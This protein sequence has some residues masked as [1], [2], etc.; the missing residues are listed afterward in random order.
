MVIRTN[1]LKV[2]RRDLAKA[3]IGRGVS[4][5][6][7]AEWSKVG[8]K[9]NDSKV[10]IGATPEYLAGHYILQSPSSFLPV[11]ALC[12]QPDEV[13]IDMAAA[14]GGKT[15][16]MA[17]LMKNKGTIIANDSQKAR[18][19]ALYANC[20]RLGVSNVIISNYDGRKLPSIVKNVDRVLLD[21]PCSGLGLISRDPSMKTQK[22]FKEISKLSAL[23]K[24]LLLAGIDC[25]NPHSKTGGYI[26][27]STCSV[28]VE[29][30]EAVINYALNHRYVK[31]VE[32][33]VQV[34]VS[35]VIAYKKYRFPA[36]MKLAR[37]VYPHVHNMDGFF[38]C[39]LKKFANGVKKKVV[40]EDKKPV[41][42]VS[43][44]DRKDSNGKKK[45]RKKK[46]RS[47]KEIE[48]E[49]LKDDYGAEDMSDGSNNVDVR[50][51]QESND[52]EPIEEDEV[53]QEKEESDMDEEK[54][55][56]EP[57]KTK[58][59]I[60]DKKQGARPEKKRKK[61]KE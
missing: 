2:K 20:Q 41:A 43:K 32:T 11:I 28:T 50:E 47:H 14:P 31:I 24:E 1:T 19:K 42:D 51:E 29:E 21:S 3:L 10:P 15:T 48:D 8:L 22:N 40:E 6:P 34:G 30:N 57:K 36:S 44:E 23:Q 9:V 16:Y 49:E 46:K 18:T 4:L 33:G 61:H 59:K 55:A 5:E 25:V 54:L 58:K 37:R 45:E 27:Y 26:V 13:V 17:Q 39:K 60:K 56:E 53:K 52:N 35:G 12:P 7:L 38:F